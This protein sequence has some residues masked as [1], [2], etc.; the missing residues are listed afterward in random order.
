M[1]GLVS[2]IIPTY[3]RAHLI[4]ETLMSIINQTYSNWECL[5]IDDGSQDNTRSVIQKY[6][7]IDSRFKYFNRPQNKK[8]GPSSC[9]NYGFD[10]SVGEFINWFDDDDIMLPKF[11][12]SKIKL[13]RN[14][15]DA[16]ICKL[17][18]Y[19][20]KENI[21]LNETNISSN[22]LISDYLQGR[23]L[24]FVSGPMWKREFLLKQNSLF[25]ENIWNL[26][27][28]DFNLRMLYATPNYILLN[29]ALAK[30]RVH[31]KSLSQKIFQL[32]SGEIKSELRA[33]TKHF[34]MLKS[35]KELNLDSF[36]N[37]TINRNRRFLIEALTLR[38]HSS[39][40]LYK[41]LLTL[42]ILSYDFRNI[43]Q[44]TIGY[45]SYRLT[46]KGYRFFK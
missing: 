13:F 2:I 23:V 31:S 5:I 22:N 29:K 44:A 41:N 15:V 34:W 42:Y 9:R 27:D 40:F 46:G 35:K 10:K 7:K 38:D 21:P 37:I 20:F 12:E 11:L 28:W 30:Y 8:K 39:L 24:F 43:F 33:R 45:L 16:V 18:H 3:N 25:D 14:N 19:N 6:V 1:K 26:D 4:E 36:K 32:D 17:Q